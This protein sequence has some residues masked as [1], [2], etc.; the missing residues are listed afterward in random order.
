VPLC[1][2][3]ILT[4]HLLRYIIAIFFVQLQNIGIKGITIA[5]GVDTVPMEAQEMRRYDWRVTVVIVILAVA[6]LIALSF[7]VTTPASPPTAN[8]ISIERPSPAAENRASPTF[9]W[10]ARFF[11]CIH[12]HYLLVSRRRKIPLDGQ[13]ILVWEETSMM[14]LK[15]FGPPNLILAVLLAA[16]WAILKD[17]ATGQMV[18][19]AMLIVAFLGSLAQFFWYMSKRKEGETY[20]TAVSAAVA[21]LTF[22]WAWTFIA[23]W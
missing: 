16:V 12:A 9:P 1:L 11:S 4:D 14:F 8:E 22:F 2:Y 21:S 5:I 7:I 13:R 20:T 6:S 10:Q 19:V 23:P 3:K 17:S 15:K 18:R